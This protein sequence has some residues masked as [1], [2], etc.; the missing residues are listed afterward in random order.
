MSVWSREQL[1]VAF[2]L[3]CRI[4]FGK[5]HHRNPEIIEYASAIGRT[6]SAMAMKLANIASLDPEITS[7]GRKGLRGA[8]SHDRAMWEEMQND[9]GGFAEEVQ[10][11]MLNVRPVLGHDVGV[12]I[13]EHGDQAGDDRVV[14]T[15]ARVGQ[16]FFRAA[17]LS[18][19]N[20]RCCITGLSLPTLLVASHIVPWSHDTRTRVNPKNGLLLSAVHDRAFD[21]GLITINDD[22]TLRVSCK[23]AAT[24][25]EFFVTA[26]EQYHGRPISRPSKFAPN[27]DF[28]AYHR[29][30][31]FRR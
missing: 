21:A 31:I 24:D 30:R 22:L 14:Q 7:T 6:S 26:I 8:S 15:T 18:A 29:D 17:V 9:W 2:G 1:L 4:P 20:G 27:R 16:S 28:L 23:A 25:D 11:A 12:A 3:Y 19:Y 5:L 10:T 13:E